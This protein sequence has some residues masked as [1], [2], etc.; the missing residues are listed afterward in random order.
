MPGDRSFAGSLAEKGRLPE[1]GH[2]D[3]TIQMRLGE[4][5]LS[6]K[7]SRQGEMETGCQ[8]IRTVW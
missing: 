3:S 2:P 8:G 5:G 6:I 7:G 4:L 1:Q